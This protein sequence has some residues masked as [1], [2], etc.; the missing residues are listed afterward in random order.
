MPVLASLQGSVSKPRYEAQLALVRTMLPILGGLLQAGS[1][2]DEVIQREV[3]SLPEGLVFGMTVF[4]TDA[5]IRLAR[6]GSHL[7]LLDNATAPEPT[8]DV[9]FKHVGIAFL[10]VTFQEST[11]LAFGR[12][13]LIVQGD[14]VYAMRITRCLNRMEA[15]TLPRLIAERALKSVPPMPLGERLSLAARYY[16]AAAKIAARGRVR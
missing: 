7:V 5:K 16:A 2:V 6:R 4:G 1:E 12:A 14:T 8:V 13:R 11:A 15:V 3:E 10:V 9:V